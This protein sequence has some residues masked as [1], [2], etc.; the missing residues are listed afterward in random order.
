MTDDVNTTLRVELEAAKAALEPQI[1]G[2]HDLS[3]VSISGELQSEVDYQTRYRERRRELIQNVLN[4]LDK[5][6]EA[7]ALLESDGY[8]AIADAQLS[9]GLLSELHDE[10]RDLE[11]AVNIFKPDGAQ[12]LSVSLGDAA[13]KPAKGKS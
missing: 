2:L 1:R 5:V 12:T 9:G 6:V 7:L 8:P 10:N 13:D 3:Q 4:L 11:A